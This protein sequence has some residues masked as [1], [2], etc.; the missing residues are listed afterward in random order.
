VGKADA[1]ALPRREIGRRKTL[2]AH[3][4]GEI[5]GADKDE[6]F[7]LHGPTLKSGSNYP[8]AQITS[9]SASFQGQG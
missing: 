2:A 3:Q 8:R 9:K 4:P 1:V 7:A 6:R 5:A